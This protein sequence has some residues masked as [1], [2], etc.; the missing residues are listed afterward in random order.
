MRIFSALLSLAIAV[1]PC[2]AQTGEVP[3]SIAISAQSDLMKVGSEILVEITLTNTSNHEIRVGKA[4][5]NQPLAESEYSIDVRDSKGHP[6]P[7][8][9]YGG[10]VRQRKIWFY[11][12]RESVALQPG[13][14]LKDGAVIT[15]LYDLSRVDRY[16]VQIS[17][18]IPEQWGKGTVKSNT[19]NI[20]VIN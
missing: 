18:P 13:E 17:R 9:E 8:T 15:K 14:S 12:S 6:A 7:D 11:R 2:S 20:T 1:I 19:I 5:G 3:F 16:T 10:K 4:P